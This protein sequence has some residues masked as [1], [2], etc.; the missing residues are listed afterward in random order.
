MASSSHISQTST[1]HFK[2]STS[3]SIHV[4]QKGKTCIAC[5]KVGHD[6]SVCRHK[7]QVCN[8][9][10]VKGHIEINCLKKQNDNI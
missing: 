4:D 1:S 3:K 7:Y 9:C 10:H 6:R 2:P 8:F 5:G